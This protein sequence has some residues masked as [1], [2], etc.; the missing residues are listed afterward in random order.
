[1][2]RP[3][4]T[5]AAWH[6]RQRWRAARRNGFDSC[7]SRR[8]TKARHFFRVLPSCVSVHDFSLKSLSHS[9]THAGNSCCQH[10]VFQTP[11]ISVPTHPIGSRGC[12]AAFQERTE[13]SM[14][15]AVLRPPR[16]AT[17][18]PDIFPC[19]ASD[20]RSL[21]APLPLKQ[22]CVGQG[23]GSSTSALFKPNQGRLPICR[24]GGFTDKFCASS[25]RRFAA[26]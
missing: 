12:A 1:M 4:T 16:P 20:S 26:T 14:A 8:P 5:V 6:A 21:L 9:R 24:F 19:T 10:R 3:L 23:P 22:Q 11:K 7:F 25:L 18:P 2:E 17:A 13:M 15:M